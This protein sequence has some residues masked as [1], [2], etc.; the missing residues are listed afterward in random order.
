LNKNKNKKIMVFYSNHSLRVQ[1][2][3]IALS[4]LQSAVWSYPSHEILEN[5]SRMLILRSQN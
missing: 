4:D 2:T 1:A 3:Q 5:L